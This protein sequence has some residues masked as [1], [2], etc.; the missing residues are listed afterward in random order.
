M[1]QQKQQQRKEY[2]KVYQKA[3]YPKHKEL[4]K[5][6]SKE[7]RIRIRYE[8]LSLYSGGKPKCNTCGEERM[9]CLSFDHI[10]GG[11]AS[12]RRQIGLHASTTYYNWL[13]DNYNPKEFQVLCMNCQFIKR[14]ENK[15]Y[16][17]TGNT[18]WR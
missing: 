11:G 18:N 7:Y 4:Y 9:A 16:R 3:Y 12:H 6:R 14:K 15:E 1:T 8:V 5:K 10:N 13:K 17:R 2:M